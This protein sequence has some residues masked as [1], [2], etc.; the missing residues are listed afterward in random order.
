M[1]DPSPCP[2]LA[3]SATIAPTT[4]SEIATFR[5]TKTCGSAQRMRTLTNICHH[6]ADIDRPSSDSST[7]V[8]VRPAMV[9]TTIGKK[10]MSTTMTIF[11][12]GPNPSHTTSSGASATFGIEFSATNNGI[13]ARSIARTAASSTA[14]SEPGR[15]RRSRSRR[16]V[17]YSGDPR[18]AQHVL[19][20]L[21]RTRRRRRAAPAGRTAGCRRRP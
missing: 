21:A 18:L 2:G 12:F 16:S 17:S 7:G 10:Q 1:T 19:R 8:D 4:A 9:A 5:P 20:V 3:I 6:D 11:G 15:Q 13:V 14:I